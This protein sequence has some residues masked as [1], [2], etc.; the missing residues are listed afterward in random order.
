ML[1][2]V[3]WILRIANWLNWIGAALF[4]VL[5]ALLLIEPDVFRSAIADAFSVQ[6]ETAVDA[7][8]RWL[9][10]TLAMVVPVAIAVHFIFTRLSMMLRDAQ[11]HTA[12][13]ETNASRLKM[14]AWALLAINIMDLLFGQLSIW[15]SAQTGEYFGWSLSLTG[16]FAVL[17]LFVLAEVFREGARMRDDLEGTV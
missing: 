16:W 11:S 13:S 7:A 1:Q 4:S 3:I 12:Y 8:W 6:G 17:L 5:L 9:V 14:I 10:G 2:T 15:A